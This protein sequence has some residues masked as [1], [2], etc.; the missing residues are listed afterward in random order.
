[1]IF[2]YPIVITGFEQLPLLSQ[3]GEARVTGID[4]NN[5]RMQA[6]L[7]A[8]LALGPSHPWPPR[9][10]TALRTPMPRHPAHIRGAWYRS[11]SINNAVLDLSS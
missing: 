10:S 8:L 5:R 2:A 9:P 3:V 1:M 6:A 11:S 7:G 4:L